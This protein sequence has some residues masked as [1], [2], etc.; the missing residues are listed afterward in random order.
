MG[1]LPA[2]LSIGRMIRVLALLCLAV[3]SMGEPE[4]EA[5]A[6]ADPKADPYLLYGGY[7]GLGH[8]Y[9]GYYGYPSYRVYGKRSAEA[10]AEAEAAPEAE[11]RL[12]L[13]LGMDTTVD[14][15]MDTT[16]DMVLDTTADTTVD[17]MATP[18]TESMA[19]GLLKLKLP[20][21]EAKAEA[22][23][24]Y[25]YCGGYGL[26]HYG[27]YYGGH[28]GYPYGGYYGVYGKRSAEAEAEATP[29]AEAKAEADPWYG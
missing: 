19:R 26:G 14:T 15:V 29:A 18:T 17:T 28:Y 6:V 2:N 5:K 20:A 27:R 7:Y 23:P 8:H 16:G 3:L 25:G 10:E 9:G 22:D 11:A 24:W 13:T 1:A 21:A 4:A 12:K